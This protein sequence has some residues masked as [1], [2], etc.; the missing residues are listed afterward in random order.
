MTDD[1]SGDGHGCGRASSAGAA[2]EDERRSILVRV[3]VTLAD[4]DR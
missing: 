3:Q 1:E 2:L 4:Y